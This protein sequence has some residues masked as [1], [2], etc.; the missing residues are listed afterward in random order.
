MNME[1]DPAIEKVEFKFTADPDD[2]GRVLAFLL[3]HPVHQR[4]VY[5]YDTRGLALSS[6]H[7]ILRGR[8][9]EGEGDTTVKLRPVE[10]D[11]A[12]GA[13]AANG[14]VRLE[15]DVVGDEPAWSAKLDRDD[16]DL[17]T[18]AAGD[19]DDLFSVKQQRLAGDVAFEDLVVLGPIAARVWE[20]EDLPGLPFKLA[21]EEWSGRDLHFVEL[22]VKVDPAKASAA[23]SAFRKFLAKHVTNVA[24][25]RS[26]K[27]ERVLQALASG[28]DPEDLRA[29]KGDVGV[30]RDLLVSDQ[31]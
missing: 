30:K 8:V 6:R 4:E 10:R 9:T 28:H 15:L 25:D 13:H 5:F 7:L 23:R 21:A 26:R 29:A 2:E 22:S 16:V 1:I 24:G 31:P 3:G 17:A 18:I 20:I 14:K 27:T 12:I 11:A 19:W